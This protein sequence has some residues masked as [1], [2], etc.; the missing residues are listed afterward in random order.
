MRTSIWTFAWVGSLVLLAIGLLLLWAAAALRRRAGLAPG[1][2]IYSDTRSWQEPPDPLYAPEVNLAG[3]PDYVVRRWRTVLPVEVKTGSAP[4][5]PYH[6]HVLQVAAYC[7]L[8]EAAY[9]VRPPYGLIHYGWGGHNLPV[10]PSF[11]VRYTPRLERELLETLDRMRQDLRDGRA[12][13]NHHDALRCRAC[14]YAAYCD[15]RLR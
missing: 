4:P 7:L 13:R 8:V 14:G 3:K 15:Q 1:R 11:A 2:V 5:E 9:G 10:R 12:D 6:S